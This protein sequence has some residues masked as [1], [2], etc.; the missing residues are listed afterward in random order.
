MQALGG[1][2]REPDSHRTLLERE[3]VKRGVRIQEVE[4]LHSGHLNKFNNKLWLWSR[5]CD[6]WSRFL[7][8]IVTLQL[9]P[10]KWTAVEAVKKQLWDKQRFKV[11]RQTVRLSTAQQAAVPHPVPFLLLKPM[12]IMM[13]HGSATG[14]DRN[15]LRNRERNKK[16]KRGS[17]HTMISNCIQTTTFQ[18]LL[19]DFNTL[20]L[21]LFFLYSRISLHS[22]GR[23]LFI[24]E[25]DVALARRI[26]DKY[27][28]S[29]VRYSDAPSY[30]NF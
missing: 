16:S 28:F 20:A 22:K 26:S 14:L 7:L 1:M 4:F 3:R 30:Y 10:H 13:R 5:R 25:K 12:F 6:P 29:N 11:I 27:S 15:H 23:V 19:S 17:S 21:R 9:C 8:L 18:F 24:N 2:T